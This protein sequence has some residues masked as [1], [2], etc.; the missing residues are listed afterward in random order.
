K[1]AFELFLDA[2]KRHPTNATAH[3]N[4]AF[5]FLRGGALAEARTLYEAALRLDPQ[6]GDAKRGLAA[7]LTQSGSTAAEIQ[8]AGGGS[9]AISVIPYRGNGAPV[10]ILLL[11]SLGTGN[12][13]VEKLLDD[14]TFEVT[15]LVVE[16]FDPAQSLPARDLVFNAIGDADS[17]GDALLAAQR[18]LSSESLVLNRP[19]LVLATTRIGTAEILAAIDGALVPRIRRVARAAL[20]AS[21]DDFEFPLLLRSPGHHTGH[22]FVRVER[23]EDLAPSAER[24]PGDELYVIRYVDFASADGKFRKY[25][26]MFVGGKLYPLHLAVASDWKVHYFS[27]QMADYPE[28]RAEDQAFL[29]RMGEVLGADAIAT[30]E[31]IAARLALDYAGIDFALGRR[32]EVIV[33]EANA[34]MVIVE[35]SD[36]ERWAYRKEPVR[37]VT[38]AV[39]KMLL[40]STPSRA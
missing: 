8:A 13:H 6:H 16:L 21:C 4:L 19:E 12:L 18:L 33:F 10:R 2:V 39:R 17:C 36:D 5:M 14:R 7:V 30:L 24:L 25:R 1:E 3:A 40:S 34:T 29:E 11:V 38:G 32:G 20:D 37:R 35:P 15:K 22:H 28:H 27:A 31:R 23:A 26:V 9:E